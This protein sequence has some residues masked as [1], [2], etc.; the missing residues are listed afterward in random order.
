M[1]DF[2]KKLIVSL[3]ES[4]DESFEKG[5]SNLSSGLR[6]MLG[7]KDGVQF[8]STIDV[9]N[10]MLSEV[11][12]GLCQHQKLAPA[13]DFSVILKWIKQNLKGDRYYMVRGSFDD[14]SVAIAIFFADEDRI[15][16]E[17]NDPKICYTC[18]VLPKDISDLFGNKNIY[19][20]PFS[21]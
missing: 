17:K 7:R 20:Q 14:G 12:K 8:S 19:V 11:S 5:K 16:A 3:A 10:Y 15:Y 4:T 13:D 21:K 9:L 6:K 2:L 1:G 18:T